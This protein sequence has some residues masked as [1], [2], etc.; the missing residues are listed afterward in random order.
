MARTYQPVAVCGESRKYGSEWEGCPARDSST[1]TDIAILRNTVARTLTRDDF[2]I[3]EEPTEADSLLDEILERGFLRV[4]AP[5]NVPGLS[6]AEED[7]SFRG[8]GVELSRAIAVALFDDPDA[9][10]FVEQE[11]A[12]R[13]S[14]TADGT[15]DI[16]IAAVQNLT[17]DGS[18]EVDYSPIY[19]YDG[20][21]V[22]VPADSEIASVGDLEGWDIGSF[23]CRTSFDR[24]CR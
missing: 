4:G 18:L 2:A 8:M 6:F 17:R 10:E 22:L 15:V 9:I 7:G 20:V 23:D 24:C 12:D 19:L 11:L 16:S 3:T 14:N 21:G 5:S 1:P 13:F